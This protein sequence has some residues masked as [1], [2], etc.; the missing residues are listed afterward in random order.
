MNFEH[1]RLFVRVAATNN[2]SRAGQELS[3]SP[4]VASSYINRLEEE[5]RVRLIHRTTRKV[6]LTEEGVAFLP[7]AEKVLASVEDAISV[8]STSSDSPRG[9][10]RVTAPASFGRMHLV[11]GLKGFLD[12]YS[13]LAIDLSFS[14]NVVDIVAGGYDLAIR[15]AALKDSSLVAC[16]LA[17][18]RRI[19]CASPSYLDK[20]GIPERPEHLKHH[21]CVILGGMESWSFHRHGHGDSTVKVAG[22]VRMDNGDAMR[23]ASVSGLGLSL[24]STWSVYQNLQ[25]GSLVQVLPDYP[26][27]GGTSIWAVYPSSRQV[28]PKVKAFIDYYRDYFGSP[29]YWDS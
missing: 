5:L 4:A 19:I 17:P 28:S 20:H 3:L 21:D 26:L 22:R 18:D 12:R 7:Y 8:V 1:L 11:P 27:M 29:P 23:D 10:L 25:S 16:A 14:D 15:D 9:T 6:S 13:E 24:N 2:I